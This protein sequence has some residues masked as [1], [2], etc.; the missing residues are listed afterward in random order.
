MQ[1]SRSSGDVIPGAYPGFH[2][3]CFQGVGHLPGEGG[4]P[5]AQQGGM[6]ERCKP[7]APE[8]NAFAL[9]KFGGR[10]KIY[11]G[12]MPLSV[13]DTGGGGQTPAYAP[14]PNK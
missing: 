13:V 8:A 6:G 4:T 7:Q 11:F 5:P 14:S 9:K 12:W 3:G 2:R 10:G 1:Q